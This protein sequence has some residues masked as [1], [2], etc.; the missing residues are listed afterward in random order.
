MSDG[1]E[2]DTGA[3]IG[4]IQGEDFI[5][6]RDEMIRRVVKNAIEGG[7]DETIRKT[8]DDVTDQGQAMGIHLLAHLRREGANPGDATIAAVTMLGALRA[9][10]IHSV[11][12][13]DKLDPNHLKM[14]DVALLSGIVQIS[15]AMGDG[16]VYEF[17]DAADAEMEAFDEEDE[18]ERNEEFQK[19]SEGEPQ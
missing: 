15:E 1:N 16:K 18:R 17:L 3:G 12:G 6:T 7:D 10:K 8:L 19:G 11:E 14:L 9:M 2:I 13:V 4:F 5:E